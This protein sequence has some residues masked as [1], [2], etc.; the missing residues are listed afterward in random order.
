MRI[1]TAISYNLDMLCFLNI[2]T[3]DELYVS[4]H[5]E[6]FEKFYPCISDKVKRSIQAMVKEQGNSMLSPKLTL[7]I[8]SLPDFNN[9]NLVEMLKCH[10]EIEISINQTPYKYTHEELDS[11]FMFVENAIIPLIK[12]LEAIDFYG[13]WKGERLPL[14]KEK[15]EI[16]DK[17]LTQYDVEQ[18]MSQYNKIDS[19]DITVYLCSFTDPLGIALCGNNVITDSSY[20][21]E[22]I[23]SNV[24]HE[25]F[26]P[27]YDS[28]AVRLSLDKIA[29]KPWVQSAFENQNPSSGYNTM[30]GFIEENIVEALGIYVVNKLGVDIDPVEYFRTHDGGSHVISPYFYKYLRENEKDSTHSFEDYFIH[31]VDTMSE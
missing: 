19:S 26:H 24:T 4:R 25:S 7:L 30:D 17:Y 28:K 18:L 23:L 21:G 22:T 11:Y 13:F 12:E 29:Q 2:M 16:I 8:S 15:C 9:R 1:K 27:P 6:M 3:E 10:A 20:R 14:I 5:K 31:F